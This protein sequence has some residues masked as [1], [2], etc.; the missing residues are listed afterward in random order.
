MKLTF[1]PLVFLFT[2]LFVL[3]QNNF[4]DN[5][6][7]WMKNWTNFDPNHEEYPQAEERL[8]NVIDSDIYIS[9][10][11]TY[12]MSGNVYVTNG[13]ILTIEAGTIIR[14]DSETSTSL[15]ITKGSKLFA[16]G[17]KVAPIVFTSD[18]KPKSRKPGDWGGIIIAGSGKVNSFS[19]LGSIEGNYLP[20]H[21]MYGGQNYDEETTVM[22][23]VRIEYAGQ[24]INQSN[25]L[26]GLSLYALGKNSI[27]DN[28]MISYS[29]DDSF[30]C[31]GGSAHLKN[32]ISYKTK[33]DDFDF[34]QG[35]KGDLHNIIAIRHP[36]ISDTSGSYAIEID[37]YNKKEGLS[38][39]ESLS[40]IKITNA[41]L[42]SLS[43][44]TNYIHTTSAISSK[45]LG[46]IEIRDSRISGFANVVRFDKSY[47][48]FSDISSAF[49]LENS[50]F[51][52]HSNTVL[53]AYESD[54]DDIGQILKYNMYTKRFKDVQDLFK[55][56]L[57]IKNPK[58][59]IKDSLDNQ[60]VMQ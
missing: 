57:H 3:S 9:N 14:C 51:N 20:H 53:A 49:S 36:Y 18:K 39:P 50:V 16:K 52:V 17:S 44:K 21:S 25:E 1:L 24:K 13:A 11:V 55:D 2:P 6:M 29:A 23:Y 8:P 59:T 31:Y 41:S 60:T 33:D 27:I 37:G 7:K 46:Q 47:Q 54:N 42:I 43:D 19:G 32:L 28:I 35:F 22:S 26:N 12:L 15:V 10:D 38:N 30:E 34:T 40:S 56:P 4:S 48:S 45:S 58:F 5:Q